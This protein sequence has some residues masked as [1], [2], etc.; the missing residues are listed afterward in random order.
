MS[1]LAAPPLVAR[2]KGLSEGWFAWLLIAPA[3]AFT[4]VIVAWPLLETIRL[5]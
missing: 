1:E 2:R 4:A 3:V 5:S